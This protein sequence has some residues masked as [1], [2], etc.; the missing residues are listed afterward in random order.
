[1]NKIKNILLYIYFIFLIHDTHPSEEAV[2]ISEFMACN[3]ST[4]EDG[5]G[6][7]SDW[8]ELHN[9]GSSLIDLTGWFLTD[10][11]SIP[12]KYSFPS[13]TVIHPNEFL[14]IFSSG[15]KPKTYIINR[16]K[17]CRT[18]LYDKNI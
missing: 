3:N 8:I 14:I 15:K 13:G 16:I 1:M 18:S 17:T 5:Y 2:I 10:S 12:D 9:Y 7:S 4:I 6:E 11:A